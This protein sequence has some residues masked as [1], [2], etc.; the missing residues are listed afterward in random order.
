MARGQTMSNDNH[1]PRHIC[2]VMGVSGVG[3]ST[4]GRSLADQLGATFLEGDDFHSNENR[5][6][7]AQG[8]ALN[9]ADRMP[10]LDR[11]V[12]ETRRARSSGDAV[13]L[14][15]SA[16]KI[17]YR[18]RLVTGIGEPC[19]IIFLHGRMDTIFER[20]GHRA[21]H[22]MPF[23]LLQSQLDALEPPTPL[24]QAIYVDTEGQPIPALVKDIRRQLA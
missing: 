12:L 2:I 4:V 24:E 9:D 14:A 1:S 8:K 23:G 21:G 7:M 15:C 19:Q 6:K 3:K 5:Q 10:W 11:L 22:F 18:K 13:V 16:L 20:M 17:V